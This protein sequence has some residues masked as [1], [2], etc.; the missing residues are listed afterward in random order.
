MRKVLGG[1]M[2]N[3]IYLVSRRFVLMAVIASM[4]G[5]P[6]AYRLIQWWLQD[7]A[8]RIETGW[9]LLAISIAS[10]FIIIFLSTGYVSWKAAIANPAKN[11]RS[12]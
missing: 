11:L 3:M 2:L 4:I 6:V 10:I 5:L 8:F 1:T 9:S 12:E 7:F